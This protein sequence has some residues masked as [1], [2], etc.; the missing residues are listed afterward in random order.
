[1]DLTIPQSVCN[2]HSSN[3][4]RFSL[5]K[6]IAHFIVVISI[7]FCNRGH[8][9]YDCALGTNTHTRTHTIYAKSFRKCREKNNE[10]PKQNENKSD[11]KNE[12]VE[13]TLVIIVWFLVLKIIKLVFHHIAA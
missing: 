3:I 1:M 8:A 4:R 9:R 2:F 5:K 12:L 11:N 13:L 7:R 6:K 10:N